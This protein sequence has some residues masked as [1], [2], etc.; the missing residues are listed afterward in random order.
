MP[1]ALQYRVQLPNSYKA[2]VLYVTPVLSCTRGSCPIGTN[3]GDYY[4]ASCRRFLRAIDRSCQRGRSYSS[5]DCN[6][7]EDRQ[8][9]ILYLRS[10]LSLGAY[11]ALRLKSQLSYA[12]LSTVQTSPRLS[13]VR[14]TGVFWRRRG[15][16]GGGGDPT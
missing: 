1:T 15:G 13:F 8:A 9:S 2:H 5:T 6:F 10:L 11:H 12:H 3:E 4:W 16:E 14:K 7:E